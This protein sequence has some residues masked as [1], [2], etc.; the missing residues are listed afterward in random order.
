MKVTDHFKT[1]NNVYRMMSEVLSMDLQKGL[2]IIVRYMF[3]NVYHLHHWIIRWKE[4]RN[5]LVLGIGDEFFGPIRGYIEEKL[6]IINQWI[7]EHQYD[8]YMLK[9]K[10]WDY[11]ISKDI[12]KEVHFE[13]IANF[14]L[15]IW[16]PK[17][18]ILVSDNIMSK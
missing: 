13:D 8:I 7:E 18:I 17:E 16:D 12:K 5:L 4:I 10:L 15:T 2:L 9:D 3:T 6:E 14:V 11:D 1:I